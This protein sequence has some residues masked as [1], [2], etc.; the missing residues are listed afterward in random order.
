[1]NWLL[2]ITKVLKDRGIKQPITF[3]TNFRDLNLD[4][5]DLMD[6]IIETEKKYNFQIPD[7]ELEKIKT[8]QDLINII[9]KT[10][11]N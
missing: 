10:L 5:L 8:V 11:Q 6:L 4:S 3:T 2:E 1:M 9:E 7:S